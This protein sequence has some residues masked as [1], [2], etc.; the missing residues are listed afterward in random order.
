M[1]LFKILSVVGEAPSLPLSLGSGQDNGG[2][3]GWGFGHRTE[4]GGTEISVKA[5]RGRLT[6]NFS[7]HEGHLED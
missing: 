4:G 1:K 7:S 5:L 6:P 2:V 3:G